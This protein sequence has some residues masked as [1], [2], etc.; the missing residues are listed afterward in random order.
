MIG[1]PCSLSHYAKTHLVEMVMAMHG[2]G[3]SD[4]KR[5]RRVLELMDLPALR[6]ALD[7]PFDFPAPSLT[8]NAGVIASTDTGRAPG[9]ARDSLT[10]LL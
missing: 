5:Y 3:S 2:R 7:E 6:C 8:E 10:T 4:P 1:D 9:S